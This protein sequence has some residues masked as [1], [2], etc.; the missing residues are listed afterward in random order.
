MIKSLSN[1][2][3][4]ALLLAVPAFALAAKT[5]AVLLVNGNT[6]TGEVKS[7]Q[8]GKLKY[9]AH[10][11]HGLESAIEGINLLFTGGNQ[12]KLMVEL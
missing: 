6:I 9:R 3:A 10:T 7:L 4:S 2:L 1:L 11:L 5:D 8:Q 12:G